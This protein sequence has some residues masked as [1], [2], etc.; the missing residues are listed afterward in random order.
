L[1]IEGV[2]FYSGLKVC[3]CLGLKVYGYLGLGVY[4]YYLTVKDIVGKVVRLIYIKA[5]RG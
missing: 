5:K 2:C 4:S 3:G 1:G